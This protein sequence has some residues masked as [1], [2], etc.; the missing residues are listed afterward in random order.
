MNTDS[1]AYFPAK[2]IASIIWGSRQW[3]RRRVPLHSFGGS[4]FLSSMIGTL[5]LSINLCGG[6]PGGSRL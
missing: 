1:L 6:N 5:V 4:K 3:Q 2:M